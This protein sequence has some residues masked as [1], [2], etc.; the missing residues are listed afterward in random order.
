M[1]EFLVSTSQT[2]PEDKELITL[3][4]T[5]TDKGVEITAKSPILGEYMRRV[6]SKK[7]TIKGGDYTPAF[8]NLEFYSLPVPL[9]NELNHT[10]IYND[11]FL[12]AS[13]VDEY[14][15]R[16]KNEPNMLWLYT[17]GLEEGVTLV[18][19]QPA[20]IPADI[21]EFLNRSMEKARVFYLKF[22]RQA[23]IKSSLIERK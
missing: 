3:E 12:V 17:K 9:S 8:D 1:T 7:S 18:F 22:V 19:L 15:N 14:G 2:V 13:G 20:H 10:G 6:C 21:I 23:T 16:R 11:M 4:A 5:V